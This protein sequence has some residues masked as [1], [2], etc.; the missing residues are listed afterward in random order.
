MASNEGFINVSNDTPF[1]T[2]HIVSDSLG[3]TAHSLAR[4]AAGQF[5]YPDPY[6]ETLPKAR[7]FRISRISS[8]IIRKTIGRPAS[9]ATSLCSIRLSTTSFA[10]FCRLSA[11]KT[12]CTRSI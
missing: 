1:P 5:G 11:R 8:R 2:I 12:A 10:I 4:A 6:I 7:H 3:A 9:L